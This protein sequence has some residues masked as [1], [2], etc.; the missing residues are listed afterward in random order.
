MRLEDIAAPHRLAGIVP[1]RAVEVLA[2]WMHGANAVEITYRDDTGALGQMVLYRADEERIERHLDAGRP[3]DADPRNFRLAAEAQRIML[4]GLH[5]PMLAVATSDVQPLPHQIRAVYGELI[6]RTPLRFLLADD[7]GAGKT[8]M[9][10]LYIKELILRDD[11]RSCLIVAPGGLVE[12]WQDE[13]ALKFGLEFDIL[14]PGSEDSA[15]GRTIFEQKPLLI[16]R[17]DQ[18]ARNEVLI[19]QLQQSEFDLIVVD[20]A[21]RMSATWFGGELKASKRFQLGELLSERT[22]HFLLMTATPHNG[23]EEDFQTFLSLLDRDRFAGPGEKRAQ[24]GTADGLM[25]RMVKERLVT[26]EG[27]P[28]FPE[29]IAETASYRLSPAEQYLYEEVTEYVRHGMNLADRLDGKR[30]NTVGFALTVLQRRL[31]SSP[32]AIFHSLRRRAER[33]DR[34]RTDL[35]NG[36]Q[37][38]TK[39]APVSLLEDDP[40]IDELDAAELEEAEE[41]LVDAATA[42]R[43]AAELQTEILDVRR[44]T[45][46]ARGLLNTQQD[47]KW[48][49]LRGVLDSEVLADH[50]GKPRKI[51]IFTEHRDTLSY[52][53]RRIVQLIGK[54]DAV[55]AIHGAVPRYER[56]RITAEFTSNPDV[57]ILLATDA[58]G[59]GLNLQ[60]AHLMVN[61]DL[62]WNP[63]RIEQRFGRIHR[64]GQTEVCRLWNLV[65][66]D[67]REGEVFIRLLDKI[68]EQRAA[69]KGEIFNVL[70][71]SLGDL[72]L[73]RVLRDAIRYGEQPAVKARMWEVI[74][75]GVSAGLQELLDDEAL[76]NEALAPTD[77]DALRRQM[78]DAKAKRLQPHF[79]RDAFIEAF[80]RLGGRIDRR[81]RGRFEI[82]HVPASIRERAGRAPIARKYERVTFD[83]ATI[84]VHG[85]PRAELLAPGHP[86]HDATLS[87]IVEQYGPTLDRGT[88]LS[89]ENVTEPTLLV[90]V[91]N[92][93]KDSTGTSVSKRFGY[94]FVGA[95]GIPHEAGPAPYLDY[96]P[97]GDAQRES[98]AALPWLTAREK[99]AVSWVIAE[100]LPGFAADV[101]S[102]R[103]AEYERIRERVST[104]LTREV[105]RLYTE[106]LKTDADAAAGRKVRYSSETLRRRAEDLEERR[107]SRLA[108]IDRQLAM[109]PVSPRITAVALVMPGISAAVPGHPSVDPDARRA[110]ER[111]GVD[112]VLALERGL[113]RTPIEQAQNNP[114]FDVLSHSPSGPG[115]RIEVKARVEGADTFTITRT[116]VLTALNAAP[117]HRLALVR[118]SPLGPVHDQVRYIG[119]AFEGVEPSWLTDFDV[120]SQNL[121]WNDWWARGDSPF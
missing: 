85:T 58:A 98:G 55:V 8:I 116:E 87:L 23:K 36:V 29:R 92:E 57:Q 75:E 4:A 7:P 109:S 37:D 70:G 68:E 107:A 64:I 52:L 105:N 31:A 6:P 93:V 95:D 73:S 59:E 106:A 51:I 80:E 62:P 67:T 24:S 43:T 34:V 1:G 30:K 89:S 45:E 78:E 54:S 38:A 15:S 115:I 32:E 56:R 81:E 72:Q 112:A 66:E 12:Q 96:A 79:I 108:L 113:G 18:L 26:F 20:E 101:T 41:E 44:L 39:E 99:D 100:Q 86:L 33:L 35:L 63:N 110:V 11:V 120:V 17:M 10:G 16:A 14:A 114:G 27:R 65:A 84:D 77:L 88:V 91:L 50:L 2:A 28:L 19:D 90:G 5:D 118:V 76:A 9:A 103:T 83:V 21:H 119:N 40:D 47:V 48:R 121:A 82:T 60:A 111:R 3:F 104:R 97:A 94:S 53:E 71:T 49:E 61:Y 74:D 25:R 69:Y 117:D 13:L 102:R 22:R 46:I 42:A